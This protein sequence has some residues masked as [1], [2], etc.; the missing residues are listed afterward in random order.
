MQQDSPIAS[1]P[2]SLLGPLGYA[3]SHPEEQFW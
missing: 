1:A 2:E 3:F